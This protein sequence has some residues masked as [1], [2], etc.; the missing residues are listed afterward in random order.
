[1]AASSTRQCGR[2]RRAQDADKVAVGLGEIA[3]AAVE[4]NAEQLAHPIG[5]PVVV[6]GENLERGRRR[7]AQ[8][9]TDLEGQ[10]FEPV[11]QGRSNGPQSGDRAASLKRY[12]RGAAELPRKLSRVSRVILGTSMSNLAV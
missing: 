12:Q 4:G 7:R 11:T 5:D 10:L 1:M 8:P 9:A 3:A 6:S 2:Q